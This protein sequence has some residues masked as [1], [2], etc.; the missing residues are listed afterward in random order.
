MGNHFETLVDIGVSAHLIEDAADGHGR[1]GLTLL[2]EKPLLRIQQGDSFAIAAPKR[3]ST[4]HDH[5]RGCSDEDTLQAELRSILSLNRYDVICV[6]FA[7][8][9]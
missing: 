2:L 1:I 9:K 3:S 5:R 6:G 7:H 8:Q 4:S